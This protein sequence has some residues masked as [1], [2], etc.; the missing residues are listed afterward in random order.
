MI[1]AVTKG[2]YSLSAVSFINSITAPF[3]SLSNSIS[4]RVENYLDKNTKATDY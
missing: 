4:M 1:F 2:G 3:K